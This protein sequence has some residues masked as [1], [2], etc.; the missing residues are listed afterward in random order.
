MSGLYTVIGNGPTGCQSSA[1]VTINVYGN[2]NGSASANPNPIT[3][4]NNLQLSA[5]GGTQY[6][7]TDQMASTLPI[8]I[9]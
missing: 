5:N 2:I 1:S 6:L 4:G 9:R 8:K 3:T 7:R